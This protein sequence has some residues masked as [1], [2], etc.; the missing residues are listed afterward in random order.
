MPP[1]PTSRRTILILSSN[2]RPNFSL[3]SP[4]K[5]KCPNQIILLDLINR[6]IFGE[7]YT[8]LS[9]RLGNLLHYPV[10]SSLLGPISTSESYSRRSSSYVP[11]S[12][13]ATKIHIQ[14]TTGKITVL[15]TLTFILVDRKMED[16]NSRT[17]W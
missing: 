9:S 1:H 5:H 10:I 14:K 17:E 15:Y 2:R 13:W 6:K 4:P 7:K 8:A 12:M 16:K 3:R 11:P